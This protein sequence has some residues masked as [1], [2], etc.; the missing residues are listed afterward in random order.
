MAFSRAH[1]LHVL[2]N[3]WG[4]SEAY[5][6]CIRLQAADELERLYRLE[7]SMVEVKHNGKVQ[8]DSGVWPVRD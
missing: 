7:D 4:F 2:R 1:V 8:S 6:R 5:V 3:P